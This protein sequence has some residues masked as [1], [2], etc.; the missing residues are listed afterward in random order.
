LHK[1]DPVLFEEKDSQIFIRKRPRPD[2][3]WDQNIS[4]TL[5]EWEDDL[6]DDL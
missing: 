6:D 3:L 5:T 1:G 2:P 4:A